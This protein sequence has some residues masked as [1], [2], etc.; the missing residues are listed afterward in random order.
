MTA[1][2]PTTHPPGHGWSLWFG[3]GGDPLE[4]PICYVEV[5]IWRKWWRETR[6]VDPWRMDPMTNIAG[7]YWRPAGPHRMAHGMPGSG[8]WE[9]RA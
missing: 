8:E 2:V 9:R 6:L 5:E 3:W 7:L 4:S 1:S